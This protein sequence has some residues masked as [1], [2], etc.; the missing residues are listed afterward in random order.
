MK[1]I[2]RIIC[3]IIALYIAIFTIVIS[4]KIEAN[5]IFDIVFNTVLI[6]SC[7]FCALFY[8]YIAKKI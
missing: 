2:K 7:T 3:I 1:L 6:L 5:N 8:M 4:T